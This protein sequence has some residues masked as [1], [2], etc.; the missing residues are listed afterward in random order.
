MRMMAPAMDI[1]F[2]LPW[3]ILM[4][5]AEGEADF[6]S[7]SYQI[8]DSM[9]LVTGMYGTSHQQWEAYG[10]GIFVIVQ[11]NGNAWS[12]ATI[13]SIHRPDHEIFKRKEGVRHTDEYYTRF[14]GIMTWNIL[15]AKRS[16]CLTQV[17]AYAVWW[18]NDC[19]GQT[20]QSDQHHHSFY[21]TNI[22]II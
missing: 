1:L 21:N 2:M 9:K 4:F 15:V 7:S 8:F 16:H 22:H 20:G 6:A 19:S 14:H 12:L 10:Y 18:C 17:L 11:R 5:I 3:N 13:Q